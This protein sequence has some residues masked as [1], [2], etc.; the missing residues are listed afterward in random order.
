MNGACS[1]KDCLDCRGRKFYNR[2]VHPCSAL[3]LPW[4]EKTH[5]EIG[6]S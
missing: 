2:L 4:Q 5:H 1:F 3:F 6:L